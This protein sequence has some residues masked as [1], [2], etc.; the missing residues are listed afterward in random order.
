ME[1]IDSI[2]K[3]D[4]LNFFDKIRSKKFLPE[5]GRMIPKISMKLVVNL[6]FND[7]GNF[8]LV[9]AAER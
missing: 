3:L 8:H 4:S 6:N 5:N 9:R 1:D 2:S 7:A